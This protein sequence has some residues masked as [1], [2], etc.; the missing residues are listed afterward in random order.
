MQ[1]GRFW[2]A[3][4]AVGAIV[5]TAGT[6][7]A[8]ETDIEVSGWIP[9]W[10]VTQGVADARKHLD[11]IDELNPFVFTV[12][13]EG[14]IVDQGKLSNS[15][16]KRLFKEARKKDVE[17]IPTVMWSDRDAIFAVLSDEEAREDHVKEIAKMVKKGKYDGVDIDY[18]GKSAAV[19][20]YFS[21]FL[22]ELKD[23]LGSKVLSC[24]MEP[25]TPPD[26]L[27]TVV[28]ATIEYSNDYAEINEHCDRIKLMT[29][30][31][32][33]ADLKQNSANKGSPYSPVA[34]AEW[35]EK[36]IKLALQ[37]FPEE[38]V[39]LGVA[40]YGYEYEITVSPDWYQGYRRLWAFNPTY[41]TDLA[42]DLDIE[43]GRNSAGE[44]GF[45]YLPDDSLYNFDSVKAPKGTSEADMVAA[46]ALAYANKTG[47][48]VFF[49]WMTWSDDI[50][51]QEKV[52]LAE[53]YDLRGIAVFKFDGGE[54]EDIWDVL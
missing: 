50:A 35:V 10:R 18:E 27:Y 39:S 22:A 49:N 28:P 45:S 15:K 7:Q 29:Y 52:D 4:V 46:K 21:L 36:V 32:G 31:Q 11:D 25:R 2:G 30:D 38:K 13:T 33:R 42:E 24:T 19:R 3:C 16:W 8:A 41:A 44:I 47:S 20:D 17:I 48:T 26:S 43:P 1:I 40:T 12:T 5:L 9:Y 51:I 6:V 37:Y 54:D 53:K 34:D 14:E 23:E